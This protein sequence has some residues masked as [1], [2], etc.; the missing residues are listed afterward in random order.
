MK[1][2]TTIDDLETVPFG[3]VLL[4]FVGYPILITGNEDNPLLEELVEERGPFTLLYPLVFDEDDVRRAA[5][6][7][8]ACQYGIP[9]E[10]C[11]RDNQDALLHEASAVLNA[12][13][14]VQ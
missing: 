10:H 13:G 9:L 7:L 12:F 4:D 8:A 2:L 14:S 11:H 6:A 3:S 5:Q 1:T